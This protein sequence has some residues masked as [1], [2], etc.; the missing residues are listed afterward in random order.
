M[1]RRRSRKWRPAVWGRGSPLNA[2]SPPR[3]AQCGSRRYSRHVVEEHWIH[4]SHL[5]AAV[6]G[7]DLQIVNRG[8]TWIRDWNC[9]RALRREDVLRKGYVAHQVLLWIS[10]RIRASQADEHAVEP[11]GGVENELVALCASACPR[12]Q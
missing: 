11:L 8:R 6:A 9:D 3:S 4:R 5:A 2:T 1:L 12:R 7:R 10:L